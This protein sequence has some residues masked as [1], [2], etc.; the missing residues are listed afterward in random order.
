MFRRLPFRRLFRATTR[1][2]IIHLFTRADTATSGR[3]ARDDGGDRI[4]AEHVSIEHA[5]TEHRGTGQPDNARGAGRAV[6]Y[7]AVHVA[8]T[9][10]MLSIPAAA[11]ADPSGPKYLAANDLPTV[12]S[13]LQTWVMGILAAVAT[14]FLVL[15]GVY[16]ATA[17]GDPQQ[18]DK[19]KSAFKNAL[20][21]YGLAVLAPVLLQVV[22]DLAP[23]L[24]V[25]FIAAH[26]SQLFA[27]KAIGLT[28]GLTDAL[29]P[30]DTDRQGA[31]DAIKSHVHD[32]QDHTVAFLFWIIV[33]LITVLLA[34]TMI[35]MIVRIAVLLVLCAAAPLALA[36]H[37]LPQT[38]PVAQVWWRAFG[39]CLL[40][41]VLQAFTLQAGQWMLEDTTHVLPE[42]G[43]P[44]DPGGIINLFVVVVLLWTTVKIPGL[45]RR[46]VS[47]G[48]RTPNFLGM[49]VRVVIVQQLTRGLGRGAGR[50][51]RAVA[52]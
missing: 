22:K 21:G 43:L 50:A 17:G 2:S 27:S 34:T 15:A 9:A 23:R 26:F 19:A 12:I 39:G 13:N 38:D 37:A 41:P 7:A 49:I 45:V 5:G 51:A 16:Y 32:A 42:L 20:I 1:R 33:A 28:A 24:A 14:L 36:C 18:V 10:L 48:G 40:V 35:A 30:G 44:V 46:F 52:R 6:R 4:A 11:F 3:T 29:T 47:Q 25:G 31:L 8:I